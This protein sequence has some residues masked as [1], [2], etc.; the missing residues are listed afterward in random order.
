MA[1]TFEL[2]SSVTVGAGG[3]STISFTSIPTTYTDLCLE[4]SARSAYSGA[5]EGIVFRF[6]NDTDAGH[7]A[8]RR[9]YG[10]G[11]SAVSDTSA[12]PLFVNSSTSTSNTFGNLAVYIPNYAGSTAKSWSA[13]LVQENNA[14][15]AYAAIVAG[16]YNQTTALSRIDMSL[17]NA[18]NFLQYTTA[19]LYGVKNA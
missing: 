16:F 4:L 7:Y 15:A 11:S 3:T 10:S 14:T 18:D 17:E 19:Y 6:N 2:I 1:T 8:H 9:L 5:L 13:D 12:A